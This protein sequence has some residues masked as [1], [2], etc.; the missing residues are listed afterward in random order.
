MSPALT[1]QETPS[2]DWGKCCNSPQVSVTN[3]VN[4][5]ES[6]ILVKCSIVKQDLLFSVVYLLSCLSLDRRFAGL[7][8]TDPDGFFKGDKNPK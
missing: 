3:K 2:G 6:G 7:N 5:K 8:P 1:A 4:S